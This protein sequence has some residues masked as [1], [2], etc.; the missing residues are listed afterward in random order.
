MTKVYLFILPFNIFVH[1]T[2]NN[3]SKSDILTSKL[4]EFIMK[5]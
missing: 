2:S 5:I 3:R 1:D 4:H